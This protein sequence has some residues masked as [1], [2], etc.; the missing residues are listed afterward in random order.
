MVDDEGSAGT[1]TVTVT[2]DPDPATVLRVSDID[3]GTK[4]RRGMV[5]VNGEV[6]VVDG[7]GGGV[8]D[9]AVHATW[10]LPDGS[11]QD[12]TTTT[13]GNGSARFEVEDGGG[14]YTLTITDVTKAGHTFD[15]DGS[16]LEA[17][18]TH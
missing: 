10:T 14:T 17:S 6:T 7:N 3:L 8:K 4:Q 16:V 1:D 11:S 5:T 9:V 13:K 12:R 2:V 18:V 15:A